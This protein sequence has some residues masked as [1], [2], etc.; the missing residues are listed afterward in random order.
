ME[1]DESDGGSEGKGSNEKHE[2]QACIQLELDQVT[3]DR[4]VCIE[5]DLSLG[6]SLE[7]GKCFK[8]AL[9]QKLAD[10]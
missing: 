5:C 6:Y 3:H 4:W 7:N 10:K 1:I 9:E 8:D 2:Y